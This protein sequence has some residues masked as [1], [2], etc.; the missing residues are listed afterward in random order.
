VTLAKKLT[1]DAQVRFRAAAGA[2]GSYTL[3]FKAWDGKLL[4]K[5]LG[6]ATLTIG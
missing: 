6:V 5:A 1:A 3:S 4:S 2:A